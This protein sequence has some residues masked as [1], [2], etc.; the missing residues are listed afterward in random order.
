VV[1]QTVH[2]Y[3]DE[4]LPAHQADALHH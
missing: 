4:W 3:L 1:A 2:R